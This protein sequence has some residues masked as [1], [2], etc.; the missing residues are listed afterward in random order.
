MDNTPISNT[1]TSPK[2][3]WGFVGL[4]C[5]IVLIGIVLLVALI[6]FN[7]SI[8]FADV[9]G[10]SMLPTLQHGDKLIVASQKEYEYGDIVAFTLEEAPQ[11]DELNIKRIIA[12]AGDRVEIDFVSGQ[13]I[14]N[15]ETL[16]E[17]Y[18]LA[19]TKEA[20][21]VTYPV[22]V[23]EGKL[24]VMGDNRNN[25]YD[26]RY[27][28]IGFVDEETVLGKVVFRVLPFGDTDVYENFNQ[29]EE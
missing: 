27:S 4:I 9:A 23:P 26:S 10:R 8:C 14:V 22:V 5:A 7:S 15:G 17:P 24:F 29:G 12:T 13:V 28:G 21:D 1:K 16:D 20:G 6:L 3:K 2:A 25:S 11:N 18:V 19:P